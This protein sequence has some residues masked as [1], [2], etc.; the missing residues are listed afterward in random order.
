VAATTEAEAQ[1]IARRV[2]GPPAAAPVDVGYA[3]LVTRTVA[4]AI[5]AAVINLVA[6]VVGVVIALVF[7]IIPESQDVR[8]A[9]VAA[10]G[11]LFLVW[12]AGYFV[13]FWSTTG[14]TL[15]NRAMRIRVTRRDGSR[16]K[17]RHA[18]VRLVGIF[19]AVLP[20]C[21][22]LA[23]ILVTDDRRGLQDYLAGS[24]VRTRSD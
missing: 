5:D 14:V 2:H 18:L 17:P 15:G 20:L 12:T 4:F 13:T 21:A 16:L 3:G 22:G 7:S 24:V 8:K 6:I 1:A 23:P 9:V 11:A 10:G 19:L